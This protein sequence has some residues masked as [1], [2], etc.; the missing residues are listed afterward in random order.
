MDDLDSLGESRKYCAFILVEQIEPDRVPWDEA[1]SVSKLHRT[2]LLSS[3]SSRDI[4][5]WDFR[6]WAAII[7]SLLF[8]YVWSPHQYLK[9]LSLL[10]YSKIGYWGGGVTYRHQPQLDESASATD[11][12]TLSRS[13]RSIDLWMS[14][15]VNPEYIRV[16][17]NSRGNSFSLGVINK[18]K[19]VNRR[20]ICLFQHIQNIHPIKAATKTTF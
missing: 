8:W 11:K 10:P 4:S 14:S 1:G 7:S 18:P 5:S 2:S 16:K 6:F 9:I 15:W 3:I 12:W 19:L 13:E 17:S 20:S